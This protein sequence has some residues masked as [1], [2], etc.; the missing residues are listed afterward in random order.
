[1]QDLRGQFDEA[2]LRLA[3]NTG[4]EI[5]SAQLKAGVQA[6][7]RSDVCEVTVLNQGP[8]PSGEDPG[9]IA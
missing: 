1:M 2:M 9:P 6:P 4:D 3:L 7:L 8:L 5:K